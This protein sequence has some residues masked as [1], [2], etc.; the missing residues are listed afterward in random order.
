V[1]FAANAI[2]TRLM[3][4]DLNFDVETNQFFAGTLVSTINFMAGIAFFIHFQDQPIFH[5]QY[6]SFIWGFCGS[7]LNILGLTWLQTSLIFGPPGL[8]SA[9]V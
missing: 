3:V 4:I 8:I 5:F 7:I 9:I 2:L 1:G 6:Q